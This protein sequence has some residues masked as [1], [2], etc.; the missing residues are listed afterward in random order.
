MVVAAVVDV[1]WVPL[2]LSPP[3]PHTP[4]SLSSLP[5]LALLKLRILAKLH[6]R[7]ADE[8][9]RN[10]Q[11]PPLPPPPPPLHCILHK[12]LGEVSSTVS[13]I[14]A[15]NTLSNGDLLQLP[16]TPFTTMSP[17][18]HTTAL[19]DAVESRLHEAVSAIPTTASPSQH[20][21]TTAHNNSTP[22]IGLAPKSATVL[23]NFRLQMHHLFSKEIQQSSS[24]RGG[25]LF[26]NALHPLA[27]W[28]RALLTW[29]VSSS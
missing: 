5:F 18:P 14:T 22:I 29:L 17:F 7:V 13:T 9:R 10:D 26:S 20:V 27:N 15:M 28:Y 23:A 8:E 21:T 16:P 12:V 25:H 11:S 4:S 3:T 1:L 19:V 24:T 6:K 2:S